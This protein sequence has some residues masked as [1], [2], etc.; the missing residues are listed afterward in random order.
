MFP[1]PA[2]H[3][4]GM[5][6]TGCG[7]MTY[8]A[9]HTWEQDLPFWGWAVR[10]MPEI[11]APLATV[12]YDIGRGAEH[13]LPVPTTNPSLSVRTRALTTPS[14]NTP[15]TRKERTHGERHRNRTP[16][17]RLVFLVHIKLG[18]RT[19]LVSTSYATPKRSQGSAGQSS[20]VGKRGV[21]ILLPCRR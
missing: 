8:H 4:K 20:C 9:A 14:P 11:L 10:A 18:C 12:T 15:P 7:N 2:F 21:E 3:I 16:S 6:N 5:C 19:T 13:M 17:G 1:H